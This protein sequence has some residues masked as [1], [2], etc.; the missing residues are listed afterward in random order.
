[1]FI[2]Q[3]ENSWPPLAWLAACDRNNDTIL[4]R[5]GGDID[6]HPE[7]FCEAIWDG[8]Y[9]A[10][11]FDQTSTVFGSGGRLRGTQVNFVSSGFISDRLQSIQLDQ[12]GYISNSLSCL[13]AVLDLHVDPWYPWYYEDFAS[14]TSRAS[15]TTDRGEVRLT[16]NRNLAWDKKQF[17]EE[18]KP[19][20][21][22]QFHDYLTYRE[23][24]SNC[25]QRLMANMA[26]EQRP[27][28]YQPL[29]TSSS[30]YD[31][32]AATILSKDMGNREVICVPDD[33]IGYN[34]SGIELIQKLEMEPLQIERSAWREKPFAEVP[35]V[36]ADGC[37]RDAWL[38]AASDHLPRKLLLTGYF[39]DSTWTKPP[40]SSDNIPPGP[41]G[42][43]M[44]EF[45]LLSGFLHCPVPSLGV[46]HIDVI[47]KI[48]SSDE[49][50]PWMINSGYD[51]PLP[52][53]IIEEAGFIRGE[54][55]VR[56]T[57]IN[58]HLFRRH[59]FDRFL[60]GTPSFRHY[61]QWL[62]DQSE[63]SAPPVEEY[64]RTS[65]LRETVEVPLFRQLFPWALEQAKQKYIV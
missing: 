11:D 1:M 32:L 47:H 50:R 15:I 35:F 9:A 29:S 5:H 28:S 43:S 31:S 59:E 10:G 46:Q 19:A 24:L 55:G 23:F 64:P 14:I 25:L 26:A 16:Y 51:R 21:E 60:A 30:G 12:V 37:G 54:F 13:A 27:F 8:N 56:K 6:T 34:D 39:G 2:Y 45:R 61:M 57:A 17:R 18:D 65:P 48:G 40:H 3:Q 36:A 20:S 42:L 33:R 49:M 41:P 7:W 62:R 58:V 22:Q 53:R 4:V 38:S 52:R 44:T 63:L